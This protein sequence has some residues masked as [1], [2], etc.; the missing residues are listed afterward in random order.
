MKSLTKEQQKPYQNG[1]TS[2][3]CKEKFKTKYL[4]DKKYREVKDRF[5][6]TGEYR[7]AAPSIGYLKYIVPKTIPIAFNNGSNYDYHFIIKGLAE[8][9]RK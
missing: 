5:H 9:L 4:K 6:Y 3:I 7:G 1:K 2:Y 8:E